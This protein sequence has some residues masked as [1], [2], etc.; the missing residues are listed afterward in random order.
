MIIIDTNVLVY[1]LFDNYHEKLSVEV[2]KKVKEWYVPQLVITEFSSAITQHYRH[3]IITKKESYDLLLALN[4]IIRNR[5]LRC[6]RRK[7]LEVALESGLSI[8]DSE[9]IA[10]AI[11]KNA[12]LITNDKK[13]IN[14]FP[15]IAKSPLSYLHK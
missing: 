3:G 10:L 4:L 13:I 7:V 5:T 8:Y 15:D 2:F 14:T 12:T 1:Y 9:F 11:Q 6:N